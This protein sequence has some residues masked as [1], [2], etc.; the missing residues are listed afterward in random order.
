MRQNHQWSQWKCHRLIHTSGVNRLVGS[1]THGETMDLHIFCNGSLEATSAVA[2]IKTNSNHETTATRFLIGKTRV[3]PLR[4]TTIPKPETQAALYKARLKTTIEEEMDLNSDKIFIWS[5][6]ITV[7]SW[8]K[9]FKLKPRLYIA[10]RIAEIRDLKSSN[11][12]NYVS[13]KDNPADQGT[14]GHTVTPTTEKYL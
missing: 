12:W 11:Q 13:S 8:L 4:Q 10:N 9:S 3:A 14:W 2:Y 5:D 1:T 7:L 6:S